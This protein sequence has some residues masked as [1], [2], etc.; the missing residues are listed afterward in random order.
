VGEANRR[1]GNGKVAY[2][3]TSTLR[4]NLIWMSGVIEVE[5]RGQFPMH[6]QLGRIT[7]SPFLRRDFKDFPPLAWLTLR[8][9]VPNCLRNIRL[10]LSRADTG[11][12]IADEQMGSQISNALALHHVALGFQ[13]DEVH[14]VHWPR[15][16]GYS[17]PEGRLLNRTAMDVGDNPDDWYV[18]E[19]PIDVMKICEFWHATKIS[20]VTLKRWDAYTPS[21]V[22]GTQAATLAK[23]IDV[24]VQWADG[25]K[26]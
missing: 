10:I 14:L 15:H 13:I 16:P 17:T 4:T 3:H 5:G 18:S 23:S 2:H 6:P 22:T 20:D 19:I 7:S 8:R 24:P 9:E 25:T 1:K 21:W 12:H 11:E 26:L